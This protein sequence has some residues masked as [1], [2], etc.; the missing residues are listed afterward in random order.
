MY[1]YRDSICHLAVTVDVHWSSHTRRGKMRRD[2]VV[3]LD[4]VYMVLSQ[5]CVCRQEGFSSAAVGHD[6]GTNKQRKSTRV[7]VVITSFAAN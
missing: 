2:V 7:A 1:L 3:V 4:L 6:T 5:S